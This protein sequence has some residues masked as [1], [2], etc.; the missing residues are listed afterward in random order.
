M[1]YQLRIVSMCLL[2]GG[3]SA[4]NVFASSQADIKN[5]TPCAYRSPSPCSVRASWRVII[6]RSPACSTARQSMNV[7]TNGVTF[8]HF[9]PF[10]TALKPVSW[11]APMLIA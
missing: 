10:L 5:A 2:S 8:L 9:S 7:R 6:P 3:A 1:M 11:S 4:V